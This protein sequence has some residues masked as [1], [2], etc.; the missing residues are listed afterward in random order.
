MDHVAI[1]AAGPQAGERTPTR[2]GIRAI[3][4]ARNL[5]LVRQ[6]ENDGWINPEEDELS[7]TDK[8]TYADED[9]LAAEEEEIRR[10][11]ENLEVDPEELLDGRFPNADD[12]PEA[13]KKVPNADGKSSDEV[14]ERSDWEV[15]D[16]WNISPVWESQ[17]IGAKREF[18]ARQRRL[19]GDERF[20]GPP[21][22]V[23]CPI[24]CGY[25]GISSRYFFDTSRTA[26]GKLF[27][28]NWK[29]TEARGHVAPFRIT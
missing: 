27:R 7:Y 25:C 29:S 26:S 12:V 19:R 2:E 11:V 15:L 16:D 3:Q 13:D 6:A 4:V 17:T 22:P 10:A 14:E 5:R 21:T 24:E 1:I 18:E 8:F 28:P 9:Q 23:S 20:P